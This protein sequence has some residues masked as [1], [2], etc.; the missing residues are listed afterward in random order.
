[1]D[2]LHEKKR[3]LKVHPARHDGRIVVELG[4]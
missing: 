4:D 2:A 1:L 3:L